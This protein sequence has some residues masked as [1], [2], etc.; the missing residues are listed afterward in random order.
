MQLCE[1]GKT[2]KAHPWYVCALHRGTEK[3]CQCDYE[4]GYVSSEPKQGQGVLSVKFRVERWPMRFGEIKESGK[5]KKK[6][7]WEL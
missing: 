5:N 3:N 6:S 7:R 1:N 4:N 2:H